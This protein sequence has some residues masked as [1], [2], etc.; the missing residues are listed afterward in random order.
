VRHSKHLT[1][2]DYAPIYGTD[3]TDLRLIVEYPLSIL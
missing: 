2:S 1:D 3:L